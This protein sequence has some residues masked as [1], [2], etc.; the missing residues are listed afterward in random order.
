[1]KKLILLIFCFVGWGY[2]CAQHLHLSPTDGGEHHH[3]HSFEDTGGLISH[4]F[5]GVVPRFAVSWQQE[6][7]AEVGVSLDFYRIG[8]NEGS[9]YV[10]FGYSNI[11][12]Y[13]SGEVM[14]RGDRTIGG[15]K[16]GVEFIMSTNVFGMA[17]GADATWYTDGVY[18]TL[19]ITPRLVLSFVYAELYYGYNILPINELRGYVGHHRIGVSCTLNPRFWKRKKAIYNDY[20]NSYL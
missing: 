13:L 20:Y 2:A 4:S 3:E 9:E 1:M 15:P 11:R 7:Y 17:V 8:Y 16:A 10:S 18:N 14:L 19:A 6:F 5:V 12:P